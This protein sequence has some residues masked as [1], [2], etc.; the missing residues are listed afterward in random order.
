MH[1]HHKQTELVEGRKKEL[2]MQGR[3]WNFDRFQ[4]CLHLWRKHCRVW[5]LLKI[6]RKTDV[7]LDVRLKLKTTNYSLDV[8]KFYLKLKSHKSL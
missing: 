1:F 7:V 3:F 4:I 2:V 8:N 5:T 6:N